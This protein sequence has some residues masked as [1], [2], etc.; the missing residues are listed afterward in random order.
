MDTLKIIPLSIPF[1]LL[2]LIVN[3][4]FKGKRL[5]VDAAHNPP[6]STRP[7]ILNLINIFSR[8]FTCLNANLR[9]YLDVSY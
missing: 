4:D 8:L 9:Q 6:S 3:T 1:T 7:Y 5:F 2:Q